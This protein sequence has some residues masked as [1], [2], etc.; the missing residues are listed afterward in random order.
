MACPLPMGAPSS[1]GLRGLVMS[2]EDQP[3]NL[4]GLEMDL[5]KSFQ[6]SWV[7]ESS[8]SQK[9]SRFSE[10]GTRGGRDDRFA[11]DSDDSDSR[12]R[13]KPPKSQRIHRP[14]GADHRNKPQ[15]PGG[16][17]P[18]GPFGKK[19]PFRKDGPRGPRPDRPLA[20]PV[21][22]VPEIQ[23]WELK[24]HPEWRGGFDQTDQDIGK[25]LRTL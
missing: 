13:R 16:D 25:G 20:E 14:H 2:S 6:P 5:M 12:H 17:K 1:H 4:S 21:H 15:G 23:G 11:D 22:R 19:P 24:F 8:S 9:I 3:Q 18:P 10:D 7:K